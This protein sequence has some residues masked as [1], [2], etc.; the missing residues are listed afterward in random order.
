MKSY[1]KFIIG[2]AVFILYVSIVLAIPLRT[3][4][5]ILDNFKKLL[6]NNNPKNLSIESNIKLFEDLNKNGLLDGGDNIRVTYTINNQTDQQY[7]F[8]TLKTNLDKGKINF[9]HNVKGA[10]SYTENKNTIEFP[11]LTIHPNQNLIIQ[12]DARVDYFSNGD[13]S[14]T[15]QP[16]LLTSKHQKF[17]SANKTEQKIKSQKPDFGSEVRKQKRQL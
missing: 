17:L 14:L 7:E 11:N 10:F 3:S 9:I 16:E 6:S 5:S 8:V 1:L 12:F 13:Q 2:V 4:A 15:T